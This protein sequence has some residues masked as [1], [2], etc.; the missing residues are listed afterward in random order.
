M[1]HAQ[2]P[3]AEMHG[4]NAM[5][6]LQE[7]LAAVGKSILLLLTHLFSPLA[8]AVVKKLDKISSIIRSE[9][10]I[11]RRTRWNQTHLSEIFRSRYDLR[12]RLK[13]AMRANPPT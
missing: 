11:R 13:N 1:A 2:N 12:K 4:K 3:H 9:L 8:Q 7:D 10:D 5:Q 6:I